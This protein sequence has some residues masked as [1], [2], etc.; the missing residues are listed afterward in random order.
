MKNRLGEGSEEQ[1]VQKREHHGDRCGDKKQVYCG[2]EVT[3]LALDMHKEGMINERVENVGISGPVTAQSST[4]TIYL[5][6]GIQC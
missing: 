3:K 1:Q 4:Q 6:I 2:T 5:N